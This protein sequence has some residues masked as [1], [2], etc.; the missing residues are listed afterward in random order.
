M[1]PASA[2]RATGFFGFDPRKPLKSPFVQ[3][4]RQEV[5]DDVDRRPNSISPRLTSDP[6][7]VRQLF[8]E[9]RGREMTDADQTNLNVPQMSERLRTS[10]L[11]ARALSE[12]SSM[13][14]EDEKRRNIRM[15]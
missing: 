14:V 1:N 6:D 10:M 5:P 9:K 11:D 13:Y 2:S 15:I 8:L 3:Q 4:G 7:R 12:I